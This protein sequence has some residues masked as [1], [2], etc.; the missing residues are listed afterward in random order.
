[1]KYFDELKRSM[2]MLAEHPNIVFLGQAVKCKGTVMYN[3]LQDVDSE[4]R[5]ELPVCEDLQMGMTNGLALTGK[6]PVSIFPRWNF[7]LLGT[8]QIVNH[9]DK[10]PYI[11]DFKTKVIIR[12]SIG[13]IRPLHPQDQ[14]TGDY[15]QAFKNMCSTIDIVRLDEPEDI[16]PAY[17]HALN[18]EDGKST[19]LVEWGDYYSE[20]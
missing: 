2:E 15:T 6:I 10:I 5:I 14:H 1:M 19:I 11:S 7:L 12:T 3:T 16:F 13:S 20:K 8:N 4:K 17:T 18:R 9:L